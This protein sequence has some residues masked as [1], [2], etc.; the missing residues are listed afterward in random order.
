MIPIIIFGMFLGIL[1]HLLQGNKRKIGFV[2]SAMMG[3]VGVI[4]G[5]IVA[6]GIINQISET[7]YISGSVILMTLG[8]VAV[9]FADEIAH[10][11]PGR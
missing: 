6:S 2:G 8:A 9:V 7:G 5:I 3:S 4:I 10:W 1:I 11:L